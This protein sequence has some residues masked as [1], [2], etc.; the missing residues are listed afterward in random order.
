MFEDNENK[1]FYFFLGLFIDI[2]VARFVLLLTYLKYLYTF[3]KKRERER[4]HF[5]GFKYLSWY[6]YTNQTFE[7]I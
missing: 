4:K 7:N 2:L 1:Q 5:Y 3:K 6:I